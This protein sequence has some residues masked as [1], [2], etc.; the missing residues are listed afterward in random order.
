MSIN[1]NLTYLYF[2]KESGI[3][4]FLQNS[5]NIRYNKAT[6]NSAD[7]SKNLNEIDSLIDLERYINQS[8]NCSLK[9]IA[10]QTSF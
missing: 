9:N 1:S 5:P 4:S 2:L 3:S 7:F 8:N 10:K 6:K